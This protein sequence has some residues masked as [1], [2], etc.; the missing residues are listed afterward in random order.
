[1]W[2]LQD[3]Q[4]YNFE[5]AIQVDWLLSTFLLRTYRTSNFLEK[6]KFCPKTISLRDID[7][8]RF[9][10]KTAELGEDKISKGYNLDLFVLLL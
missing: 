5:S 7:D 1:M 3:W 6:K 8:L 2:R 4:E 9:F 10:S